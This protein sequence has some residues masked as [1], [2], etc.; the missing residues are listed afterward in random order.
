MLRI[1]NKPLKTLVVYPYSWAV[2]AILIIFTTIF[3]LWFPPSLLI[4]LLIIA[5]DIL[6]LGIWFVLAFKSEKFKEIFSKMPY[7][8]NTAMILETLSSCPASFKKPATEFVEL[9][10]S[11][12]K[13]FS[14]EASQYEF[15]LMLANLLVLSKNHKKLHDRSLHFGTEEQK[16]RMESIM[17][18]QVKTI[19]NTLNTL[20]TFSGN[21]TLIAANQEQGTSATD[22]LKYINQGMQEVIE[23]FEE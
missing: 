10:K 20:K 6:G 9:I 1:E 2:L 3:H 15:E 5:I 19:N 4:T 21:L 14:S 17:K 16:Q 23:E 18:Q 7:E 11:I 13:E 12:T 8:E 22:E